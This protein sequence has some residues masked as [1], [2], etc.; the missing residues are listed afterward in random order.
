MARPSTKPVESA[1]P[2][3]SLTVVPDPVPPLPE[4]VA[5][6]PEP[7]KLLKMK[8]GYWP[9]PGTRYIWEGK[10]EIGQQVREERVVPMETADEQLRKLHKIKPGMRVY[11]PVAEARR[12]LNMGRAM[13]DDLDI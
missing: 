10:N 9:S 3:I 8:Y 11:V 2:E 13:L 7:L 5:P 4:P 1:T 6:M 12:L